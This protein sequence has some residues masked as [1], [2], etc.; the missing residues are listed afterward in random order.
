[1]PLPALPADNTRRLFLDYTS[2]SIEHTLLIRVPDLLSPTQEQAFAIDIANV[3][4]TRMDGDDAFT[5]LRY[6]DKNSNVTFP[7]PWTPIQGA[8]STTVGIWEQDPESVF[9]SF[10]GRGASSGRKIRFQFFTAVKSTAWPADN[11]YNPGESA[12]VDTLRENL[13]PLLSGNDVSPVAAVTIGGDYI[14]FN[15]YVNIAS[16]AYW[17]RRQR[18][19]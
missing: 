9:L 19:N 7:Y 4:A 17:Q 18:T 3:L 12:P 10:V 11:R 8:L 5:S 6:A 15:N 1:M 2:Q 16:N 14:S 13:L